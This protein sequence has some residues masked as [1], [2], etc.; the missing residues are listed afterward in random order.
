M[1]AP[2]RDVFL[3]SVALARR[4]AK[5]RGLDGL[6]I[7]G[8]AEGEFCLASYGGTLRQCHELGGLVDF[9]TEAIEQE[10]VRLPSLDT[11]GPP[12]PFEQSRSEYD[13]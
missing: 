10:K 7:I 3:P 9:I 2:R 5:Q 4:L 13:V 6:V 8:F 11:G 1:T 12:A